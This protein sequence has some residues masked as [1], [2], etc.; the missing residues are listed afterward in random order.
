MGYDLAELDKK[1]YYTN[2]K[3]KEDS[4]SEKYSFTND[5]NN[6]FNIT[7]PNNSDVLNGKTDNWEQKVFD[8]NA[9]I[10]LDTNK[11]PEYKNH[12]SYEIVGT[13]L[14]ALV[15]ISNKYYYGVSV[16]ADVLRG[17]QSE[18]IKRHKLDVIPE[19]NRLSYMTKEDVTVF[20]YWLINKHYILKTKGRYPVL[21]ITNEGL[22]YKEHMTPRKLKNLVD[23][24]NSD[25]REKRI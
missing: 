7:E 14:S 4:A 5:K 22:H 23:V 20:I 17:S 13:I 11:F 21:H 1:T 25:E 19:Y 15:H 12:S 18:K 2:E 8:R 16:L 3:K 10:E 24:L 6:E 9:L